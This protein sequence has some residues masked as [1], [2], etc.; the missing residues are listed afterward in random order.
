MISHVDPAHPDAQEALLRYLD[1]V[2]TLIPTAVVGPQEID[3]VEA[4]RPPD[5]GF[6]VIRQDNQVVGCGAVR[7]LDA[8]LGEIKRMWVESSH[9]GCGLGARLLVELEATC[10]RLGH[11][12]VRLDTNEAL[13]AAMRLY[14]RH[15]YAQIP[16][17]NS[18]PDAT[19]FYEKRLSSSRSRHR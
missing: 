8:G 4:Y 12:V 16:R 18:N 3:D 7:T 1:E 15:G 19:H 10:R 13:G 14:E 2:A 6:V 17:Y 9:R 5:G 11:R